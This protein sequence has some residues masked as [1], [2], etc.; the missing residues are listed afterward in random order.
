MEDGASNSSGLA[1][2][3][4]AGLVLSLAL[5]AIALP[6]FVRPP[7]R[8]TS[9]KNACISHLKQMDGAAQQWALENKKTATDTYSFSDMTRLAYLK[10]SVLPKC[11]QGGRYSPGTN[12][13]DAPKCSIPGHTL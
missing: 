2:S 8:R 7:G 1:W 6:N 5:A 13:T 3:V 9:P 4:G 12:L 10:G 11:P